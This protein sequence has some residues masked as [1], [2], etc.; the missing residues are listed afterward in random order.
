[1]TGAASN[2][3]F[4]SGGSYMNTVDLKIVG[5]ANIGNLT[6]GQWTINSGNSTITGGSGALLTMPSGIANIGTTNL[7]KFTET[8]PASANTST[9]ISPNMSSGTIVRYTANANFSF[10]GFTSAVAGQSGTVI[11]TQD[12][13]GGRT[14][15]S[16][17]KFA[18]GSKT[19]ST[20]ANAI[21][22]ISVFYDGTTYYAVLTKAFA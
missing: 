2:I 9:S 20:A 16:T 8:L 14:M 22:I 3:A 12:A 1:M 6:M 17:M 15:T 10:N 18:G 7:V 13:T 11:I 4:Q 21:D 19:L 5:T